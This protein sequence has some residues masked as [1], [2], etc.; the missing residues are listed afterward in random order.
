MLISNYWLVLI[1]IK[2]M[3]LSLEML[4]VDSVL[5][6]LWYLYQYT[7]S[8]VSQWNENDM[9]NIMFEGSRLFSQAISNTYGGRLR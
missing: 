9:F 5:Q 2:V 1:V 8:P 3:R 6:L 7:I 4:L